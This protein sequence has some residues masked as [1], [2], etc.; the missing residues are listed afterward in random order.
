MF[1]VYSSLSA[2]FLSYLTLISAQTRVNDY[3]NST[4]CLSQR[5]LGL[6]WSEPDAISTK[7]EYWASAEAW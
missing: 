2:V 7:W 5:H 1:S 3:P 4:H 6:V